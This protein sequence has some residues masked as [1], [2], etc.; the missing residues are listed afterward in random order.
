M[1]SDSSLAQV[2][3]EENQDEEEKGL[4]VSTVAVAAVRSASPATTVSTTP[5]ELKRKTHSGRLGGSGG[6]GRLSVSSG[7]DVR[8]QLV[9]VS[10]ALGVPFSIFDSNFPRLCGLADHF[11][12]ASADKL[13]PTVIGESDARFRAT[14]TKGNV[15]P[16]FSRTCAWR[17]RL[18]T[19]N[20]V[21]L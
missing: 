3:V 11:G 8:K 2:A 5:A 7:L 12:S 15:V 1:A 16:L 13:L 20:V 17:W 4:S 10:L 6:G 19:S 18:G 9:R 14:F 21:V